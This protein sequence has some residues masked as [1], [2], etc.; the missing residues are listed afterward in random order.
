YTWHYENLLAQ[1]KEAHIWHKNPSV[2]PFSVEAY[3]RAMAMGHIRKPGLEQLLTGDFRDSIP[4]DSDWFYRQN[5]SGKPNANRFRR[6]DLRCFMGELVLTKV[7]RA[8]MA[9]SLEVRVPFLENELVD[10]MLR[11]SPKQVYKSGVQKFQLYQIIKNK[12]P[13]EILQ[14]KKQGFVGPDRYYRSAKWYAG[15]IS[16]SELVADGIIRKSELKHY[17][18]NHMY[19]KLWKFA[20]LENWYKRWM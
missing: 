14:R 10:F 12:M 7:D 1:K 13:R 2:P 6:M 4:E 3:S 19:W 11:L 17:L 5:A 9:H 16:A 15:I 20:V 18:D 8:S